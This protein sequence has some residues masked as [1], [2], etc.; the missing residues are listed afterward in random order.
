M[1]LPQRGCRLED[2]G[3]PMGRPHPQFLS[4]TRAYAH[5]GGY[6]PCNSLDRYL[7]VNLVNINALF[8]AVGA[9]SKVDGGC[10]NVVQQHEHH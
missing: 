2:V 5:R 6:S 10:N 1:R 9:E 4:F 8:T 7:F 3:V